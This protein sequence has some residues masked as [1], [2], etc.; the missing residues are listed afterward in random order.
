MEPRHTG[1]IS[2]KDLERSEAIA[3]QQVAAVDAN[4]VLK[5]AKR[6]AKP[7]TKKHKGTS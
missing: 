5:P 2:A 4:D 6:K 1:N 7:T 3:L